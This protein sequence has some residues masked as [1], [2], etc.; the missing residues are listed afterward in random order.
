MDSH[1]THPA[2]LRLLL[3]GDTT[4][5]DAA[6]A[7]SKTTEMPVHVHVAARAEDVVRCLAPSGHGYT[8]VLV[9]PERAGDWISTLVGLTTAE[10][11]PGVTLVV[12]GTASLPGLGPVDARFVP[13]PDAG[14]LALLADP[15]H[16]HTPRP[17]PSLEIDEL[18]EA[19]GSG[20]IHARYQ[21]IVRISDRRPVGLEVLARLEH[22]RHG[23]IRPDL[24]VPKIEA[25][26]LAWDLT[27]IMFDR[28]CTDWAAGMLA[29]F[30]LS[31]AVNVPLDVLLMPA[32][33]TALE[34][35]RAACGLPAGHVVIELTESREVERMGEIAAAVSRL[36]DLGYGVAID[37][38]GPK[39]R[40]HR[41]L[42]DLPFTML[43]LDKELVRDPAPS[44]ASRAFLADTIAA[45][46]RANLTVVAEGVESTEIWA[47]MA[48]AGV[49]QAQGFLVARPLPARAVGPWHDDW[50]AKISR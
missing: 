12:L 5:I 14:W 41:P 15:P 44:A 18:R 37:D 30:G 27:R 21:P 13:R 23:T 6:R 49:D 33:L 46:R 3:S 42:L 32:A 29:G 25:A 8:H 40:D 28:A 34:E 11:C 19:L 4:W 35:R 26:G 9:Q 22:P 24:F 16:R 48:R 50:C 38:V 17:D 31:L 45:A 43:K 1:S 7:E 36:R 20:R 39:I 47:G 2:S 10:E